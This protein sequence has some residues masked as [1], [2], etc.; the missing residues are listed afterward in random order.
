MPLSQ[1]LGLHTALTLP[2]GHLYIAGGAIGAVGAFQ[3]VAVAYTYDPTNGAWTAR[4]PL[5]SARQAH[6][7]TWTPE[8]V[9]LVGGADQ[10]A[11]TATPP[12]AAQA[13]STAILWTP[14]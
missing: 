4:T 3:G 10:G 11:P 8:G 13:L 7:A 5:P 12:V 6:T 14:N 1:T 9:L 2:S